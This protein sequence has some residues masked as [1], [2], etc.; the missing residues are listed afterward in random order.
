VL[1]RISVLA[2]RPRHTI[3]A[4]SVVLAAVGV[5]VG[6][7]ASFTAHSA[8]ATQ[9]FSAGSLSITGPGASAILSADDMVPGESRT[10]VADVQNS[11]SVQGAFALDATDKQGSGLLLDA[12]E[13]QVKDC[14]RWTGVNAPSCDAGDPTL[15]AGDVAGLVISQSANRVNLGIWQAG[16]KHRFELKTTLPA[17]SGNEYQGLGGSVVFNW[18]AVAGS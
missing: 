2:A 8:S 12:L 11:G 13:L 4:L 15:Y 16:D 10:G 14:G 7:S 1:S 18:Y 5:A 17:G 3:G 6:S 9:T